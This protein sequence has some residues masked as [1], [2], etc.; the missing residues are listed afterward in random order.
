VARNLYAIFVRWAGTP[1]T[2][3]N[4]QKI[5][6]ALG[7]YGDWLRFSGSNWLLDTDH[8]SE[9][10]FKA[11][12]NILHKDDSELIMKVDPNDYSGWASGWVDNWLK[13]KRKPPI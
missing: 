1:N 2:P 11:L 7:P 12:A 10:I 4:I 13:S 5:D 3:E 6:N 8:S 9:V